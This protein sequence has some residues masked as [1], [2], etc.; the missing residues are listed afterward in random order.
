LIGF[1]SPLAMLVRARLRAHWLFGFASPLA[2]LC[3]KPRW[4]H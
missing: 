4:T 1:A 2:F 3:Q